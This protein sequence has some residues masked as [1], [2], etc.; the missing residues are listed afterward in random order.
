MK[1]YSTTTVNFAKMLH[2]PVP[3]VK[4]WTSGSLS[5]K[6]QGTDRAYALEFSCLLLKMFCLKYVIRVFLSI[7]VVGKKDSSLL[8]RAAPSCAEAKYSFSSIRTFLL[9]Q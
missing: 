2:V 7:S 4:A 9:L 6:A 8:W 1:L 3:R 5:T